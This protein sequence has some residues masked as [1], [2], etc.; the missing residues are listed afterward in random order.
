MDGQ[1][2]LDGGEAPDGALARWAAVLIPFGVVDEVAL[3][4]WTHLT[5]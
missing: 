4:E 5:K 1:T 3:V 2:G